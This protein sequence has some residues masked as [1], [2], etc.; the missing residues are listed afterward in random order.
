MNDLLSK[1]IDETCP[2]FNKN[3]T[4]GTSKEIMRTIPAYLDEVFKSSIKSLSPNVPLR[5][6]GYRKLQPEEEFNTLILNDNNKT[7]YDTT[8]SNIYAVEYIFDYN[9]EMIKKPLYLPFSDRGNIFTISSTKYSIVPVLSD[10]VISPS[11][12][13]IFVR[14]LKDKLTFKSQ[15]RNFTVN[16]ER[17]PGHVIYTNIVKTSTMS[18]KDNIGKPLTSVSLYLLGQY[19]MKE[20]MKRYAKTDKYIITDQDVSKYRKDY[21]VYESTKIK[22]RSLKELGY[23]GHDV[24]IL[25]HKSVKISHFLENF[26]FGVIYTLD[27]LPEHAEDMVSVVNGNALSDEILYWR[28]ILGRV[29]YK[30]SFSVDRIV[31]D[32]SDHFN[33]LQG[34]LDNL[35]K[36]KLSDTGIKV[37]NFFDLL[38]VLIENF[39]TWILN[40]KEY[41][42][43]IN[44]RYIDILYYILYDI[45]IS[46]NKVILNINKRANKKNGSI[47]SYKEVVKIIGDIKTKTI[48]Q[49][50]KSS[51]PNLALQ[52]V[53]CTSDIM[54]PKITALLED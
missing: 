25:I 18:L 8:V 12:K 9:G 6:V 27:I 36:S 31:E 40:S 16:E 5:Y 32:M 48:F 7:V 22:P 1:I 41:N 28:I 51:S 39:N 42:S 4:E 30:N 29:S 15:S 20:T 43:D 52:Q 49:L 46:F 2:K 33:T 26:I 17:V 3:V 54:Y 10:T 21:N 13:Q 45:I 11:F 37:D 47:L 34:Y 44:N 38:Y 14:L 23:K 50:V 19:G 24:K 53:E 35:I